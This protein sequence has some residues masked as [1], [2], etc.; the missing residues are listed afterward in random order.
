MIDYVHSL[1]HVRSLKLISVHNYDELQTQHL[2]LHVIHI[3]LFSF[4][5]YDNA[6]PF[7]VCLA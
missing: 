1:R 3:G 4:Q 7:S 2:G 6:L 5:C